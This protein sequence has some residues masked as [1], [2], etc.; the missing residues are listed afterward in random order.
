MVYVFARPL[1]LA[2]LGLFAAATLVVVGC[3][4]MPEE[5]SAAQAHAAA[6][7]ATAAQAKHRSRRARRKGSALAALDRLAV[8]GR[9]P[10]T[11]YDRDQFGTGWASLNGCDTRERILA[12]DLRRTTGA[13]C[14]LQSGRLADPYTATSIRFVRGG[15]SEVDIDHVVALGDAWQKGA[16]TWTYAKR[17]RFANDPLNLLAVDASANRQKGDGDAATWLVPNKS[18]RCAYVARQIAV[19]RRY[20]AWVTRAERDA[21][22][23]VLTRC[24][25]TPLPTGA[26]VRVRVVERAVRPRPAPTAAPRPNGRVF[27]NC[28]AVR[29]AGRAPL[30]RGD[31]AYAANPRLDRDKDGVACE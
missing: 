13:S 7:T 11:G 16:Q 15:A 31:P 27:A 28:D 12:R 22:Q 25:R 14:H 9:A 23:R 4:G 18:F 3:G 26:R 21:M 2:L 24:P 19:K 29:A 5:P 8:K 10:K 6:P 1:R 30:L 20:R 17:V